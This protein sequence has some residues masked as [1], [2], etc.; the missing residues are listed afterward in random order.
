MRS[1]REKGD[2]MGKSNLEANQEEALRIATPELEK[3]VQNEIASRM[4]A[5]G[6]AILGCNRDA[7][8]SLRTAVGL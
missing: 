5:A 8:R 3:G 7:I 2:G 4:M 6:Y 1:R